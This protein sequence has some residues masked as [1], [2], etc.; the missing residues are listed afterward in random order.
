MRRSR[1]QH[2]V[3]SIPYPA[4]R[5]SSI[6]KPRRCVSM[7]REALSKDR[8]C[9]SRDRE[10]VSKDRRGCAKPS[11][12]ISKHPQRVSKARRAP[13]KP[14][15]SISKNPEA[16]SMNP[17]ASA[18]ARDGFQSAANAFQ[19]TGEVFRRAGELLQGCQER[20]RSNAKLPQRSWQAFQRGPK[21]PERPGDWIPRQ[22][23]NYLVKGWRHDSSCHSGQAYRRCVQI[24]PSHPPTEGRW[25]N[26]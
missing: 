1:I 14:P 21:A 26:T 8:R 20:L 10:A 17:R 18:I 5:I 23:R 12:W 7:N 11:Q 15:G 4:S 16:I 2:R 3:S 13:A 9:V 25:I 24:S 19:R 22:A 6:S